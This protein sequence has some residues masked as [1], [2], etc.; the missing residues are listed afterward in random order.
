MAV[1]WSDLTWPRKSSKFNLHHLRK[2]SKGC[3]MVLLTSKEGVS[4]VEIKMYLHFKNATSFIATLN[5]LLKRMLSS[6]TA[7]AFTK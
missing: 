7:I 2:I 1:K 5:E 6:F 3:K 4:F